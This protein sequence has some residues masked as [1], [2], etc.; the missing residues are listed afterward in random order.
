MAQLEAWRII[1]WFKGGRKVQIVVLKGSGGISAYGG[2]DAR[3]AA[4]Q[5]EEAKRG[6]ITEGP[7]SESQLR[8]VI[9]VQG[10]DQR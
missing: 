7:L 1:R 2:N 10:G 9:E 5:I 6:N 8:R 4:A 3:K